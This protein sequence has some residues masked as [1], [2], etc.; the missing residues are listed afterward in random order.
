MGLNGVPRLTKWPSV[1]AVDLD[2]LVKNYGATFFREA[3]RR[4][5]VISQHTGTQLTSY[6]L[7]ERILYANIP[8]TSLPVYHKLKFIATTD[9][10]LAKGVTLDAIHVRPERQ[11][12][13]QTVP[14]RFDAALIDV[15]PDETGL[16]S[17]LLALIV[18]S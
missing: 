15:R 12:K 14:A 16:Q 17:A 9:S 13:R 5:I 4:H 2:D 10:N 18:L 6:Q 8:F 7:E 11:S 3:L 1:K